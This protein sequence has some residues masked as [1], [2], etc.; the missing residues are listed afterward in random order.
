[1]FKVA[2]MTLVS[3]ADNH[4]GDRIPEMA[5]CCSC[6]L[7]TVNYYNSMPPNIGM[8]TCMNVTTNP[9]H[10]QFWQFIRGCIQNRENKLGL[11]VL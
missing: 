3:F 8:I 10:G 7:N 1:M 5:F 6:L 2:M 9:N 4:S 11:H